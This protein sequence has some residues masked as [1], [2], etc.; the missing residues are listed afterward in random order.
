MIA[1]EYVVLD[2]APAICM[3]LNRRARVSLRPGEAGKHRVCAPGFLQGVRDFSAIGEIAAELPLLAAVW[4]QCPPATSAAL[5]INIDTRE[6]F[7][8]DEKLG[9]GSSA[10]AT[11]ALVAA[12]ATRFETGADALQAAIAA[13]RELQNG[14]GSGADV[15]CSSLGGIVEYEMQNARTATLLWPDDLHYALLWSGRSSSTPRQLDK[16]AG[17][18]PDGAAIALGQAA[19]DVLAAWHST[20]TDRILVTMQRYAAAL[21]QFDDEHRLGIFAAGHAELARQ[22]ESFDLVYKPCGAGGG[23]FGIAIARDRQAL[24]NFVAAARK[25]RFEPMDLSIEPA[26]VIVEKNNS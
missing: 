20:A 17:I 24:D 6:F 1:G 21:R 13:H 25:E 3:A 4:H 2:G 9:I 11:V 14:R 12:F 5:S 26:G 18:T 22:A 23:D 7:C 16:L 15:A 8:G 19:R 10:A